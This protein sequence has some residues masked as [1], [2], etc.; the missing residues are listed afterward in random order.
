MKRWPDEIK[1]SYDPGDGDEDEGGEDTG[2]EG[3]G[4]GPGPVT[5]GETAEAIAEA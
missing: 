4:P 3:E 1:R 2:T 5:A